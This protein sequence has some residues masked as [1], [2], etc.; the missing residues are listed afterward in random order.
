MIAMTVAFGIAYA[1]TQ[2]PDAHGMIDKYF[3][4]LA[5]FFVT[6]GELLLSPI[7]LVMITILVPQQLVALMMGVW[8]VTLG[9]GV[10]LAGAIAGYS[11]IPRDIHSLTDITQIYGGAFL[12]Y[13]EISAIC[14]IVALMTVPLLNKW[15]R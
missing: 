12:H 9:L 4:V 1:G 15:V 6:V 11:A 5:Y 10:K 2:H 3:V 7:G 14:A 8:F 13:A